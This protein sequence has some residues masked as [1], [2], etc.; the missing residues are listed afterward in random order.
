MLPNHSATY[1]V[2][3]LLHWANEKPESI[4]LMQ[5]EQGSYRSYT[6]LE[7]ADEI[8][9]M[10]SA[11][12]AQDW[13]AG[14]PIAIAGMNCAHWFLADLAIQMAGH[15]TV[16]IYPR[17]NAEATHWVLSHSEAKAIFLGPMPSPMA[18]NLLQ[19][20]MTEGILRISLP[21][22]SAPPGD[23]TW[24]AFTKSHLPIRRYTPPDLSTMATLV[25]TSG[26]T[27][28]AK[29]VMLSYGNL[30][31]TSAVLRE[32]V[33][34]EKNERLFSYLPL[35]HV[36]ERIG[37]EL[38]SLYWGSEV[39]FLERVEKLNEQLLEA[40]PTRFTAVPLML[41]RMMNNFTARIPERKL[42]SLVR[43]RWL[44]PLLQKRLVA[45][46]G[47]GRCRTLFSAAAPIPHATLVFFRDVLG[48][49]VYDCYGQTEAL[50]CSLNRPSA[51]R[52]GSV[53]RPFSD[54]NLRISS[55]GEI[56]VR[57]PGVMLGYYKDPE[58]TAAAFTEDGWLKTGDLG[59][60]DADGFLFITGRI[61]DNFKTDK[62][63]YVA[64]V[65]IE[66]A[67]M[68][69]SAV[70]DQVCLVGEHLSQPVM[71]VSLSN[72]AAKQSRDAIED[73]LIAAMDA[74][75]ESLEDHE[76]MAKVIVVKEPWTVE[77]GMLTPT[78]KKRRN[79]LEKLYSDLIRSA[80]KRRAVLVEWP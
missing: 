22:A 4:W 57:H 5:P 48:I 45:R 61:K 43:R 10:A 76:K 75:N 2:Q 9:R 59:R 65:P 29:G 60:L 34:E 78:M 80:A 17:Q 51:Y 47:L 74:V 19:Q 37:V 49:D 35:A 33:P 14:S 13:P 67:F 6:W 26:T 39:Y 56:Q 11:L 40:Q 31:F 70:A 30:S 68:G 41:T 24:S 28:E 55:E 50:Y 52:L 25:Y 18:T 27:G 66:M 44:G 7:A 32:A 20:G 63:R 71:L 23:V 58:Q 16:G 73:D 36:Y 8:G 12:K 79:N 3:Q 42:R 77:S 62:G 46:L 15:V 38:A 72:T 54:A 1:P 21:Y 69:R 53:G 64:P